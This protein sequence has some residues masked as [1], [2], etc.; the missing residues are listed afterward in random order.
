MVLHNDIQGCLNI[1]FHKNKKIKQQKLFLYERLLLCEDLPPPTSEKKLQS[2]GISKE[3]LSKIYLL[4]FKA[5]KEVKYI[6]I[7]NVPI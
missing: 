1:C 7:S 6:I 2:Y 5:T 4:S 3:N